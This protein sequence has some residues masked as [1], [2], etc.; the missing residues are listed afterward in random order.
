MTLNKIIPPAS[1]TQIRQLISSYSD[2]TAGYVFGSQA[3]GTSHAKSD[4]DLGF[5]CFNK[6][7]I[8]IP[9]LQLDL[10]RLLPTQNVDVTVADL[11]DLP[12]LLTQMLSGPVIYQKNSRDRI[13]LETQ[14][15]K[16]FEDYLALKRIKDLYLDQSFTQGVYAH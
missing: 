12:L 3:H 9:K 10:T 6:A 7:N 14:I 15:I 2:I 1:L 8:D 5:I 16:R 13:F 4:L 11:N